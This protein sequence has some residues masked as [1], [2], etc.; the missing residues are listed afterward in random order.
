MIVPN[1][2]NILSNSACCTSKRIPQI[3]KF[4]PFIVSELGLAYETLKQKKLIRLNKTLSKSSHTLIVLFCKRIPFNV[5]I[6]LV[7]SSG[8]KKLTKA[9]P[10][11]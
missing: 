4:A 2:V 10:R 5:F 11:L 7:A 3:Y 8:F 1:G 6:A 9:Y